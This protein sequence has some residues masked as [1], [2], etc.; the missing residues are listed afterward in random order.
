VTMTASVLF[1]RLLLG[2]TLG[3]LALPR[4]PIAAQQRRLSDGDSIP[5]EL[6]L[7]L[8]RVTQ[9]SFLT[10]AQP[11]D[12]ELLVGALPSRALARLYVPS[13]ARIVGASTIADLMTGILS[14]PGSLDS[15]RGQFKRELGKAGWTARPT[16]AA[17]YM[18][19]GGFR[20]PPTPANATE[21]ALVLCRENELLSVG[22]QPGRDFG[23]IMVTL[24]LYPTS[25]GSATCT[26]PQP[27]PVGVAS[28]LPTV[29]NPPGS[30]DDYQ[31]FQA[32]STNGTSGRIRS[33]LTSDAL[34]DFYG[35]QLAD[36]GWTAVAP[37]A[38]ITGRTWAR[39]DSAGGT[40]ETTITVATTPRD[41]ACREL[42]MQGRRR[43]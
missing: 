24:Q 19:G 16:F 26:Q 30:V 18:R 36:S 40:I 34:L 6:A 31:C 5:R 11:A 43:P 13:N 39:K 37:G 7:A 41:P 29:M 3:G 21:Q 28:P 12:P 25:L 20:P 8:L 35:R 27:P 17:A 42:N 33:T 10:G 32:T 14:V 38:T 22:F 2:A 4:G 9:L 23:A 15:V 1:R